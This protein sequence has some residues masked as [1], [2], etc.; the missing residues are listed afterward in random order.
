MSLYATSIK[1]S[2]GGEAEGRA[3][4]GADPKALYRTYRVPT[5]VGMNACGNWRAISKVAF[6]PVQ[7]WGTTTFG[8]ISWS[9][10]MVGGM[11]GSKIEPVRW[12]PPITA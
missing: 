5:L 8:P 2:E 1:G 4:V 10:W 3:C 11:M 9:A 7:C 6:Q 12:N